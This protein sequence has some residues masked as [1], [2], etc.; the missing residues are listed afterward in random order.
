MAIETFNERNLTIEL[1]DGEVVRINWLGK[2]TAREPSQFVLPVLSKALELAAAGDKPIEI[3][4]QRLEYMNSSTIT[5]LI[6]I[7]EQAKRGS[8]KVKVIYSKALKW[9]SLSFTALQVFKT[10]D[11]RIEIVGT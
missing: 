7:L 4:F 8:A 9:Q 10:E 6:R 3:D 11:G 5:P 1:D 2:S